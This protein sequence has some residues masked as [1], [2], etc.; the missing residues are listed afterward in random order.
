MYFTINFYKTF[1]QYFLHTD[2]PETFLS[3]A[4]VTNPI[5]NVTLKNEPFYSEV[6]YNPYKDKGTGNRAYWKSISDATKNNWDPPQDPDSII[7]GYPFWLMLWG[8]E[9]YTK[10]LG[11]LKNLD[12]DY[13]LVLRSSYF[14]EGYPA[15]VPLGRSFIDG[16]APFGNEP[17]YITAYDRQ[18]WVPKWKFQREAIDTILMA[19]PGTCKAENTQSIQAFL[20][21][22]IFF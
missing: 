20:K 11:K 9:E 10:K 18:H 19:G 12:N 17:E 5:G 4:N 14:S 1:K 16:Q 15:Y 3:K 8:W 21:Y 7:E 13:V 2:K 22:V 6:R